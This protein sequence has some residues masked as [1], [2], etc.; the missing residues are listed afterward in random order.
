MTKATIRTV[1]PDDVD[2]LVELHIDAFGNRDNSEAQLR[3]YYQK[4]LTWCIEEAEGRDGSLVGVIDDRIAAMVLAAPGTLQLDGQ[5]IPGRTGTLLA[6]RSGH[7]DVTVARRLLDE[8]FQADYAYTLA[9]RVNDLGRRSAERSGMIFY[10]SYSLRWAR[11]VTPGRAVAGG[12]L[13]RRGQAGRFEDALVRGSARAIDAVSARL[14][15]PLTSPPRVRGGLTTRELLV[16][17][18]ATYG[19]DILSAYRLR[20][21]FSS[22]ERIRAQ[23][24][25]FEIMR[26]EGVMHRVAVSSKKG[27]LVGWYLLHVWPSGTS[28]VVQL[29]GRPGHLDRV[30]VAL[31]MHA[32]ELK[33]G[34]LHG[35]AHPSL[36]IAL[37]DIGATFHGRGAGFGIHSPLDEVHAAFALGQAYTTVL[38]GEYMLQLPRAIKEDEPD[39]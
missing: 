37:A 34:S 7:G 35:H 29:A 23:W 33:V 1:R 20:P 39:S 28:E 9:D 31:L 32:I 24:Q 13:N 8:L 5:V 19:D 36:L 14:G 22:P 27:E 18:L 11:V 12:V 30:V 2:E 3:D 6:A 38:D 21:D 16:D 25:R 4:A 10:P 26:P 15:D 17:D